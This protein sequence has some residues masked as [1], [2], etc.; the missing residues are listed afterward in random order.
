M[1]GHVM[2]SVWIAGISLIMR[3]SVFRNVPFRE[4]KPPVRIARFIATSPACDRK[5]GRSCGIQVPVWYISILF[6]HF[7]ISSMDSEKSPSVLLIDERKRNR[8]AFRSYMSVI[9]N[10]TLNFLS[11]CP[12]ACFNVPLQPRICVF[13]WRPWS[14]LLV[15]FLQVRGS[16]GC[17][18]R[19]TVM[20]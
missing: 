11:A 5:S 9:K 4:A 17:L 13:L 7:I 19:Y 1:A 14:A 6:S 2:L 20:M 3:S 16:E 15:L 8:S 12:Y 10:W 18:Y